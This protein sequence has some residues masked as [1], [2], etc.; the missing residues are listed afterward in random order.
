M[1]SQKVDRVQ[2]RRIQL[3]RFRKTAGCLVPQSLAPLDVT[4]EQEKRDAVRQFRTGNCQFLAG[5]LIIA[6]TAKIMVGHGEM[7]LSR[8]RAQLQR[9]LYR[10]FGVGNA[11]GIE[12]ELEEIQKIMS[13][14]SAGECQSEFWVPCRCLI[15]EIDRLQER[16]LW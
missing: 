8:V 13:P 1:I 2:I 9:H 10:V 15:E 4:V 14:G 16:S 7:G 3:N 6:V 12:I 5:S 11:A